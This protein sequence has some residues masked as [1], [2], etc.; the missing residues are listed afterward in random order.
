MIIFILILILNTPMIENE[1]TLIIVESVEEAGM[2]F[3]RHDFSA[4]GLR[5]EWTAKLYKVDLKKGTVKE[6]EIPK[7]N[8]TKKRKAIK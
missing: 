5:V 7:I 4:D 3:H 8:F 2:I 6:I 1:R